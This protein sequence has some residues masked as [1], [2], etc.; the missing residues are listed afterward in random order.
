LRA[1][2]AHPNRSV[3]ALASRWRDRWIPPVSVRPI[4]GGCTDCNGQAA[5]PLAPLAQR[6]SF[7]GMEHSVGIAG[8]S[9]ATFLGK[10]APKTSR[11]AGRSF[12]RDHL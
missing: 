10:F 5:F 1:V 2:Q 7:A 6:F 12:L 11:V 3:G 9:A 8:V 4:P